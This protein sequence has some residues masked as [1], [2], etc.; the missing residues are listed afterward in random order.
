M[1]LVK[2]L[3]KILEKSNPEA[4]VCIPFLFDYVPVDVVYEIINGEYLDSV[5]EKHKSDLLIIK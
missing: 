2:D 5:E 4:V 1:I 3:I